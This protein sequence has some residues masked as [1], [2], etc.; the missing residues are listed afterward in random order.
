MSDDAYDRVTRYAEKN[1]TSRSA[2]LE[3]IINRFLDRV[4]RGDPEDLTV[5]RT[6]LNLELRRK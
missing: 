4:D 3:K 6:T 1:N 5:C 2:T